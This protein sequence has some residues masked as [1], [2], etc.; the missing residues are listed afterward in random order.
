MLTQGS[1][2]RRPRRSSAA[3]RIAGSVGYLCPTLQPCEAGQGH[4]ADALARTVIA[5]RRSSTK[6]SF[7]QRVGVMPKKTFLGSNFGGGSFM[8]RCSSG[9]VGSAWEL[10][11]GDLETG[12]IRAGR[13]TSRS[14]APWHPAGGRRSA[15]RAALGIGGR[16]DHEIDVGSTAPY[17]SVQLVRQLV[18]D[19][20]IQSLMMARAIGP[21]F[22][23][24]KISLL[25]AA[26]RALGPDPGAS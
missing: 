20:D 11:V 2:T 6:S 23:S 9:G 4:L 26:S 22:S 14:R 13:P 16:R 19:A 7:H 1:E 15:S 24:P 21:S 8:A 10:P 25:S 17:A 18:P 3:L 5:D 12:L